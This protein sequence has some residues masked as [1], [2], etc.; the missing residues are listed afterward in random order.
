MRKVCLAFLLSCFLI[1]ILY[2]Q[3]INKVK[4]DTLLQDAAATHSEAVIIYQDNK[5]IA[6]KYFG[7]GQP[8]TKIESMSCTK[9][10]AG[11]AVACLL[12]D[13][14]I[15][16][17]DIPVCHFYPEWKQGQKQFITLRQLLNMTSGLQNVPNTSVEIYPSRDFVQLAL[18]AELSTKPGEVWSYNNKAINLLA[19]IIQKITGQRMDTYIRERLFKPL[20]I[21]DVNW[22]LDSAG[23]PQVMAGCQIKP[24]DFAK[25]GLL[26]LNQGRYNQQEIIAGKYIQ[27]LLTPCKQYDG[28]GL[29]WWIDYENTTSVVDEDI[30]SQLRKAGVPDDFIQ[31]TEKLKGTYDSDDAFFAKIQSVF[32]DNPWDLLRNTLGTT[33]H[34]RKKIH[35]GSIS[36]RADGY[37]GNYIIIDPTH[38]IV[39]I[40]MISDQSYVDEKDD[41]TGFRDQVLNLAK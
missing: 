3:G 24:A 10:I 23:N 8:I 17:L 5:L 36:Y 41:F 19:G 28:Y 30:I 25:L 18:C 9:S 7:I 35:S 4:L 34:I 39:A 27:A 37:L 21:T 13:K 11:L 32:G 29:L 2:G 22:E 20:G 12:T 38:K 40:R 14:K 15:D 26:V 6:D 31:N 16:S 33:L 1:P